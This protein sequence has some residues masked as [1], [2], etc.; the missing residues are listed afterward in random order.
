MTWGI[1]AA[2]GNSYNYAIPKLFCWLADIITEANCIYYIVVAVLLQYNLQSFSSTIP[3]RKFRGC[4]FSCNSIFCLIWKISRVVNFVELGVSLSRMRKQSL[5][6]VLATHEKR[7]I[8]NTS[9]F[10]TCMYNLF[11]SLS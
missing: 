4:K 7:E 3:G 11:T 1:E 5:S 2:T 9:K 8:K 10:S 6:R